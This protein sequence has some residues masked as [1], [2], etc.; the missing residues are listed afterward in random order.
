MSSANRYRGRRVQP[1]RGPKALDPTGFEEWLM[2]A[3]ESDRRGDT[4]AAITQ[5]EK[6]LEMLQ[7]D[8]EDTR[9][10]DALRY[11]GSVYRGRG[12]V[13]RADRR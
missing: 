2:R 6:A 1:L 8:E 7:T 5:Y 4:G 9:A 11:L 10:V 12:D 3:R 13:E